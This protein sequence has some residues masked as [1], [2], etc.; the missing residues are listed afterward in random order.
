VVDH[1]I[2]EIKPEPIAGGAPQGILEQIG[3]E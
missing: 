1:R 2:V 3:A